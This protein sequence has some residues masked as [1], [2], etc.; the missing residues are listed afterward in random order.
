M[1]T[2]GFASFKYRAILHDPDVYE[3]PE[4][5]LPER[6]ITGEGT[7][8]AD[9]VSASFGFGRRWGEAYPDIILLLQAH[10]SCINF[11]DM[12]RQ[13]PSGG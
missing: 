4:I 11:Q 2:A 10:S 7:L 8:S 5:F 13:I 3:D 12:S 9:N 1:L 6:F